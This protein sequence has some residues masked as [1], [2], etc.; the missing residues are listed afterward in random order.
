MSK[1]FK[2]YHAL[3][4]SAGFSE[5]MGAFKPLLP[6]GDGTLLER[7]IGIY[8]KAGVPSITVVNGHRGDE[9]QAVATRAGAASARNP[10]PE[11]G[12]FSSV[13]AGIAAIPSSI[14]RTFIHPVDIPLVRADTI[15]LLLR[16]ASESDA[17]VLMPFYGDQPGH[18]PL[19]AAELFSAIL[20]SGGEGGLRA[21]LEGKRQTAVPVADREILF[22]LDRM[23][24]YHEARQRVADKSGLTADEAE[25]LLRLYFRVPSHLYVH[26]ALVARLTGIMVDALARQGVK[27]SRELAE[28]GAWLHDIG[29][30]M[31]GHAEAGADILRGLG[32]PA[33]AEIV[34][35]HNAFEWPEDEPFDERAV[36]ALAD[37][38][39]QG[40]DLVTI[41]ERFGAKR[42]LFA[43]DPDAL[44]AVE[45]RLAG[46]R[47]LVARFEGL[48][49]RKLP[50]VVLES[51][52]IS[53]T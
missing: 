42:D 34:L 17:P 32:F 50:M 2:D 10:H 30:G 11:N 7:L 24:D 49:K 3:I 28:A 5:R 1:D 38:M 16:A 29:K 53:A 12:M 26:S 45:R 48:A 23:D 25:K 43:D 33:L 6:L 9:V 40:G 51:A 31:P 21:V 13:Q 18:P 41:D 19:V 44:N 36:V 27:L 39:A 20:D 15:T 4:L 22:D 35:V 46:A 47:R 14:C 8:R 37:K 52:P